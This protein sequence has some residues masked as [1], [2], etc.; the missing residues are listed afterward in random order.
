MK[1]LVAV[2]GSATSLKAVQHASRLFGGAL[3][4]T[5]INVHPDEHLKRFASTVGKD[6]VEG[7]LNDMHTAD[8]N[9]SK[10]WLD[11][12]NI[13]YDVMLGRGQAAQTVAD[14][15]ADGNFDVVVIGAKGRNSVADLV[16]GSMVTRLIAISKVPVLVVT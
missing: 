8:L 16:I 4:L 6:A 15:A 13:R 9:E 14:G 7:Y 2:D 12:N 11:A 1:I 5:L 10:A 3:Q